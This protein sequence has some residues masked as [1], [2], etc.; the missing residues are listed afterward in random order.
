[1][2]TKSTTDPK[3]TESE[4]PKTTETP[5]TPDTD[6]APNTFSQAEVDAVAAKVRKEAREAAAKEAKEAAAKAIADAEKAQRE[7]ALKDQQKFEELAETR[8]KEIAEL[9]NRETSLATELDETK[10]S[11]ERANA[12]LSL[13]LATLEKSLTIPDAVKEL[14]EGKSVVDKLEWLSKNADTF[15][16][17][18]KDDGGKNPNETK[19]PVKSIPTTPDG[20]KASKAPADDKAARAVN[21][22][23]YL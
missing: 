23:S 13:H 5:E 16:S 9:T 1:M 2:T 12:A 17:A 22:R 6:E 3:T 20:R 7:A 21:P 15:K 14:L 8:A 10:A 18:P 19:P 4:D 11:L